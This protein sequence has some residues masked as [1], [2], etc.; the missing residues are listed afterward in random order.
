[1]SVLRYVEWSCI[2]GQFWVIA[3]FIW[4]VP[5]VKL[6]SHIIDML[7]SPLR[8]VNGTSY[9][10]FDHFIWDF[11]TLKS[12]IFCASCPVETTSTKM[13]SLKLAINYFIGISV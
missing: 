8:G 6:L 5:T 13:L 3:H 1:M 2:F 9:T 12:G 11:R 10:D 7:I 4:L